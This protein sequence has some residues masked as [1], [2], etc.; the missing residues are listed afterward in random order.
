[1][2]PK[3]FTKLSALVDGSFTVLS[4]SEHTYKFWDAAQ[5]KML[6]SDSPQKG[7]RKI[8]PV[9]TDKGWMDLGGGQLGNLLE[10]VF[11]GGKSDLINQT[12]HVKSNG[13]SGIDIRYYFNPVKS[14]VQQTDDNSQVSL[15]D[16]PPEWTGE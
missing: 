4:V 9:E 7:Y 1:M 3:T 2:E 5:S 15:D 10:A 11:Y 16:V 13:K 8:Y 14:E 6:T 12:F